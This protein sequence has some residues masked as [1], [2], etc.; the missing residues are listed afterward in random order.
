[1]RGQRYGNIYQSIRFLFCFSLFSDLD[2]GH[3]APKVAFLLLDFQSLECNIVSLAQR[4]FPILLRLLIF[5]V[6]LFF[7]EL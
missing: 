6:R 5:R 1:M 2:S 7:D 4:Y 3:V